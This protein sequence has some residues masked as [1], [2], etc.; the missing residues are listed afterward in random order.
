VPTIFEIVVVGVAPSR[1]SDDAGGNVPCGSAARQA[2][3]PLQA[4]EATTGQR[5]VHRGLV[6]AFSFPTG[7][8]PAARARRGE[9]RTTLRPCQIMPL[10]LREAKKGAGD[11]HVTKRSERNSTS[12][13]TCISSRR[14]ARQVSK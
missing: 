6:P 12:F 13:A 10:T 1:R 3:H 5:A 8:R 4:L 14:Q 7:G 11:G 2:A 9:L